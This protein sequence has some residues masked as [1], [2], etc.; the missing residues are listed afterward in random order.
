[1]SNDNKIKE[2]QMKTLYDRLKPEIKI[3]LL[4]SSRK[5]EY[6]PRQVI[7]DLHR[8]ERYSDLTIDTV[9]GLCVYG[10]I[11]EWKWRNTDWKYGDTFFNN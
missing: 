8:F 4:E 9:R 1:M 5:Y 11:D 7:A 6:G 3:A 2:N 10:D